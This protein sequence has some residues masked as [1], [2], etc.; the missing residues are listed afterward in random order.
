MKPMQSQSFSKQKQI[1]SDVQIWDL[2]N[3]I[4]SSYQQLSQGMETNMGV[5]DPEELE[6]ITDS[7]VVGRWLLKNGLIRYA[8][9]AEE[10]KRNIQKDGKILRETVQCLRKNGIYL[11]EGQEILNRI[12]DFYETSALPRV[13]LTF[14]AP[15][16]EEFKPTA[17]PKF[18]TKMEDWYTALTHIVAEYS[19]EFTLGEYDRVNCAEFYKKHIKELYCLVILYHILGEYK[20]QEEERKKLNLPTV[21]EC[22]NLK[23]KLTELNNEL[24]KA[25]SDSNKKS[26]T[27]RSLQ[28]E[29]ER[30]RT[31]LLKLEKQLAH[32]EKEQAPGLRSQLETVQKENTALRKQLGEGKRMSCPNTPNVENDSIAGIDLP[33]SDVVF[34]GGHSR[35]INK[36]KQIYPKWTYVNDDDYKMNTTGY[37]GK[38]LFFWANHIS[39][40]MQEK[41]YCEHGKETPIVYVKATN[42]DLLQREMKL[43]YKAILDKT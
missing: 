4:R 28:Q 7:W 1:G 24:Q 40:G 38:V 31:K 14:Y 12:G 3:T 36:L 29:N 13:L 20:V 6:I 2:R 11:E 9:N 33:D 43:G 16:A 37:P 5:R 34:L 32:A 10:L 15:A 23:R 25:T 30:M 19:S 22:N 27:I 17:F 41:I 18:R 35:M 8:K 42:I 26:G 21:E 39:H